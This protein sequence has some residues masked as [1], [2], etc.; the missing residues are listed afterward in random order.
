MGPR[1]LTR[2]TGA[3]KSL[4]REWMLTSSICNAVRRGASQETL[5][6]VVRG[7][8]RPSRYRHRL[9]GNRYRL[10]CG[11]RAR[12][13]RRLLWPNSRLPVTFRDRLLHRWK[14]TA[15]NQ[16]HER[17]LRVEVRS[18][19]LGLRFLGSSAASPHAVGTSLGVSAA[20][21]L[22]PETK[23][24]AIKLL[25]QIRQLSLRQRERLG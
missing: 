7:A 4:P 16:A 25:R 23:G 9:M 13:A 18:F 19:S 3:L 22:D 21:M 17:P 1:R 15:V 2:R 20:Q 6:P 11:R 12:E 5:L 14:Q 10:H 8:S 24:S